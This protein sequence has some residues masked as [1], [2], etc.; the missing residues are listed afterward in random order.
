MWSV[1]RNIIQIRKN[2]C[3]CFC[4]HQGRIHEIASTHKLTLPRLPARS[5]EQSYFE[6]GVATSFKPIPA[7]G[8]WTVTAHAEKKISK[9]DED[10]QWSSTVQ[11]KLGNCYWERWQMAKQGWGGVGLSCQWKFNKQFK[12]SHNTAMGNKSRSGSAVTV[13]AESR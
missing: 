11:I 2:A 3:E 10:R 9:I 13:Q 1:S 12:V 5:H 8:T 4:C 6:S 7:P